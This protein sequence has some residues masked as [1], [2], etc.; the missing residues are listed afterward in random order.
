MKG[1]CKVRPY[2]AA[3]GDFIS[4]YFASVY[5]RNRLAPLTGERGGIGYVSTGLKAG[6]GP[7][8]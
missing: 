8:F 6:I 1:T 3:S 5:N 7:K 2:G 4:N